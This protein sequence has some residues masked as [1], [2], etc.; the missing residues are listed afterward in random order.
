[1]HM[2]VGL[3][4]NVYGS[5]LYDVLVFP[6][7]PAQFANASKD[8]LETGAGSYR[9]HI[10]NYRARVVFAF[11]RGNL[12]EPEVVAVSNFVSFKNY[13]EPLQQHLALTNKPNE[14]L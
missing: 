10:V 8:Y 3:V 6:T 14:M 11:I 12:I 5:L 13:N 1:M 4:C 9:F 7:V 2:Y